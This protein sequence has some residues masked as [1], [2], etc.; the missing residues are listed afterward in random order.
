MIAEVKTKPSALNVSNLEDI[1]FLLKES[2][3]R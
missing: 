3:E 1:I 2:E